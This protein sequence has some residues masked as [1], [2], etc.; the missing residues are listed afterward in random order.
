MPSPGSVRAMSSARQPPW[1]G[2]AAPV[3]TAASRR[4]ER[5]LTSELARGRRCPHDPPAGASPPPPADRLRPRR[6]WPAGS[7]PC[8]GARA[9]VVARPRLSRAARLRRVEGANVR[10][11]GPAACT[12]G[13]AS[14]ACGAPGACWNRSSRGCMSE[15]CVRWMRSLARPHARSRFTPAVGRVP[16][17]VRSGGRCPPTPGPLVERGA[18]R[19]RSRGAPR[20]GDRFGSSAAPDLAAVGPLALRP[21][22]AAGLPLSFDLRSGEGY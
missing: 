6:A 3:P 16:A 18:R 22:I 4:A 11:S 19:S 1:C 5:G 2:G 13:R 15:G 9:T 20:I 21:R 14:I 7:S 10:R 8:R 12:P 17:R